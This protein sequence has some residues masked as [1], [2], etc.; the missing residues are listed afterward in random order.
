MRYFTH[1]ILVVAT[2]FSQQTFAADFSGTWR[3][4]KGLE[5]FG[6][7]NVPVTTSPV[8]QIVNN[9]AAFSSNCF[10][11]LGKARYVYSG[12]FQSLLKEGVDESKLEKY[13]NKNFSFSITGNKDYVEADVDAN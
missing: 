5:Y 12:P 9:R 1:S 10:V 2:L 3:Y 11:A 6:Q 13:L 7:V 4:E 8:I